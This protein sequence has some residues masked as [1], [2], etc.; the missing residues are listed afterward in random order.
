MHKEQRRNSESSSGGSS[1]DDS[2]PD[3]AP[4]VLD[5]I[6]DRRSSDVSEYSSVADERRPSAI[7]ADGSLLIYSRRP[8]GLE[9][10]QEVEEDLP[11]RVEVIH[12]G[13]ELLDA[14]D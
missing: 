8:S 6:D 14:S 1:T 5:L 3:F 13:A 4:V 12:E 11:R 9:A 10:F 7:S 2:S